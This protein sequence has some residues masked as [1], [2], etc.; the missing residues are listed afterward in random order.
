M[1][2]LQSNNLYTLI[3]FFFNWTDEKYN[4]LVIFE[5]STLFLFLEKEKEQIKWKH[6]IKLKLLLEM[7]LRNI[8]KNDH[9]FNFSIKNIIYK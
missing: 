4:T 2:K 1:I 5:F 8:E 6:E 9:L 7:P 3:L